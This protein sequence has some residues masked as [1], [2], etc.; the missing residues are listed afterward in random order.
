[1]PF[2]RQALGIGMQGT[3]VAI[4]RQVFQALGRAVVERSAKVGRR[5]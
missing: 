4:V 3:P 1:L 2:G 5:G